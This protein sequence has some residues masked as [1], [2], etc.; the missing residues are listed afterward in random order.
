[1][2]NHNR[3]SAEITDESMTAILDLVKGIETQMADVGVSLSTDEKR[4]LPRI[5][6]KVM[7]F[8]DKALEYAE[9][10]PQVV[11]NYLDMDEFRR[12]MDV[13]KKLFNLQKH[14][15][16]VLSRVTDTLMLAG[17]D[18]YTCSRMFYH[19]A[20]TAANANQPGTGAIVKELGKLYQ[21]SKPQ[22]TK[23]E[24]ETQPDEN[25]ES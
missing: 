12:D 17:S 25:S 5:G 7:E 2:M 16:P 24:D 3:L 8:M 11:P 1:M 22:T 18:S 10:N 20:K 4:A 21:R 9:K 6:P 19:Q 13:T 23:T 14:L 15:L